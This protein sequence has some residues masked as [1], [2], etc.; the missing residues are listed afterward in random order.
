[1]LL[2]VKFLT[3]KLYR[4]LRATVDQHDTISVNLFMVCKRKYSMLQ[5]NVFPLKAMV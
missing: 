1:M 3:E 5:N 2:N 4:L